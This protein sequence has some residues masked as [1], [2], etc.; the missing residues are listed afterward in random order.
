MTWSNGHIIMDKREDTQ[1]APYA[2]EEANGKFKLL[3]LSPSATRGTRFIRL[4]PAF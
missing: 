2:N 3:S 4:I 1:H